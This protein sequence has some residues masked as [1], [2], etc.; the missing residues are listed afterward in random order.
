M[1]IYA[2]VKGNWVE[3][4]DNDSIE[5]MVPEQFFNDIIHKRITVNDF[6]NVKY[7]YNDYSLHISQIQ[8]Q[9]EN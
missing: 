2:N 1:A 3:L 4:G 6:V 9:Y 5:N 8:H 7:N